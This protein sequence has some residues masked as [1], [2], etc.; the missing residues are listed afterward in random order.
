MYNKGSIIIY[1]KGSGTFQVTCKVLEELGDLRFLSHSK[2]NGN[3]D[4]ETGAAS[5]S[6]HILELQ[7]NGWVEEEKEWEPEEGKNYWFVFSNG[8]V[9]I[10][11]WND[12]P[13][14][15]NRLDFGNVFPTEEAALEA[16]ERIKKLLKG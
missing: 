8:E 5:E 4:W 13:T 9:G 2:E 7:R 16:A 3:K 14:D 1:Q 6:Y 10:D 11:K 12:C 15:T